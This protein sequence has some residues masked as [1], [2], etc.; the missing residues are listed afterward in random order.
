MIFL[1]Y[2]NKLMF[3][4]GAGSLVLT[5]LDRENK[6]GYAAISPRTNLKMVNIF[7]K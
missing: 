7:A 1:L 4:E 5:R 6:I 3:L 2:A